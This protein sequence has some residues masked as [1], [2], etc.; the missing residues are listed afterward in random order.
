MEFSIAKITL[1]K[2]CQ[3]SQCDFLTEMLL[4]KRYN[5]DYV[6]EIIGA[7]QASVSR[8]L[9]RHVTVIPEKKVKPIIPVSLDIL[10]ELRQ[11]Y[12]EMRAVDSDGRLLVEYNRE[13]RQTL[14]LLSKLL[15]VA[16]RMPQED[17]VDWEDIQVTIMDALTPFAQA[18][19]AVAKALVVKVLKA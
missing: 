19:E 6:A 15:L 2:L 3:H 13:A 11:L 5:Q 9:D 7:S 4:R 14:E 12:T 18:R 17:T 8:H 16:E 10:G 1:C